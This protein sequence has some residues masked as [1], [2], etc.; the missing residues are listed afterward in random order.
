M[1]QPKKLTTAEKSAKR[2][3]TVM[4]PYRERMRNTIHYV[5]QGGSAQVA[6][7]N[8]KLLKNTL[9]TDA[10]EDVVRRSM[11]YIEFTKLVHEH[12]FRLKQLIDFS[13]GRRTTRLDCSYLNTIS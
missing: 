7:S 10:V 2:I 4:Q 13:D 11:A 5:N 12:N 3:S 8:L 1:G 6:Y 9:E